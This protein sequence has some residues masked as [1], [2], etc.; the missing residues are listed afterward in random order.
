MKTHFKFHIDKKVYTGDIKECSEIDNACYFTVKNEFSDVLFEKIDYTKQKLLEELGIEEII[1]GGIWP[2]TT[3]E[4]CYKILCFITDKLPQCPMFK[5]GD[6]VRIKPRVGEAY[7]Y[8]CYYD[9]RMNNLTGK[10]FTITEV[11]YS[12]YEDYEYP[13]WDKSVYSLNG[14]ASSFIWTVEML[15]KVETIKEA[16]ITPKYPY[17][18]GDLTP[19]SK[20]TFHLGADDVV[21]GRIPSHGKYVVLEYPNK[22]LVKTIFEAF[23]EPIDE[24][25]ENIW[26]VSSDTISMLKRWKDQNPNSIDSTQSLTQNNKQN[27]V[28]ELQNQKADFTRREIP[29]RSRLR[30]R[31][32]KATIS[33]KPISY[34]EISYRRRE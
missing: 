3:F 24:D 23:H 32:T 7:E 31:I 34:S 15:K 17:I 33:V 28:F 22:T 9:D 10:E 30:C 6:K 13:T 1:K 4:D 16:E 18:I 12:R 21:E 8:Q 14:E 27:V 11:R 25:R 2:Y 26:P 29:R 5:V 20:I 19:N